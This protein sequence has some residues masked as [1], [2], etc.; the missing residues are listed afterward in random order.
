VRTKGVEKM[1]IIVPALLVGLAVFG[2]PFVIVTLSPIYTIAVIAGMALVCL[3]F[4]RIIRPIWIVAIV[5]ICAPFVDI[6]RATYLKDIPFVGIYQELILLLMLVS[7]IITTGSRTKLRRLGSVDYLIFLYV[8]WNLFEVIQSPSILGGLY[9]WRWYSVGPL[10]YLVFRL[11]SFTKRDCAVV[12]VSVCTGLVAAA[13][14]VFYQYF[15]LGPE[16]AAQIAQS[17]G[18]AVFYRIGWRLPGSFSSP[19]VASASY[20]ILILFGVALIFVKRLNWLG[21]CLIGIGSLAIFITLSRSGIAIGL[22][23]L[24]AILIM[25]FKRIRSK[26]LPTILAI[27]LAFQ[28]SYIVPEVRQFFSYMTNTNLDSFDTDRINQFTHI[29]T[30]A[31]TKY[32]FGIGFAGGGAISIEAYKMF[33]GDSTYM[34]QYKNLGGDSVL[35]A[36]LQT[37]GFLG[38]FLLIAIYAIFIGT[39]FRLLTCDLDDYQRVLSL[40]S[41]GFFLGTVISLGNLIDVWPLKLYFWFFGAM[42]MNFQASLTKIPVEM[43]SSIL[44]EGTRNAT[45]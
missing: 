9:V 18:F 31:V 5:F 4:L 11:Y 14:Y 42:V 25:N 16:N 19:L 30:D 45:A 38:F 26:L 7:K 36:T 32:P 23:G 20:S 43:L 40:V 44:N 39:S 41:L 13:I 35:L 37:S 6:L 2:L 15:I 28:F 24:T 27:L 22:I 17:L 33:G 21:F 34:P 12:I 3:I 1:K 8:L 29:L 10:T